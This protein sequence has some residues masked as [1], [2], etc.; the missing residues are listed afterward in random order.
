MKK[1]VL[2]LILLAITISLQ[3][4]QLLI[5]FS[6]EKA[7][8][9]RDMGSFM[10]QSKMEQTTNCINAFEKM[11]K[12]NKI[13]DTWFPKMA[14]NCNAMTERT[15]TPFTHFI[16]YLNAVMA[17]ANSKTSDTH[18][19]AW[20]DFIGDVI[21]GQKKGDNGGFLKAIDFSDSFFTDGSLLANASKSWKIIATDYKFES[22]GLRPYVSFPAGCTLLGCV[23]GDTLAIH[24]TSGDYYPLETKWEGKTGKVDWGRAGLDPGRVYCTFKNYAINTS[25]YNYAIDTVTF[26][27]AEYFKNTLTGKLIDKM[28]SSADTGTMSYP[29][30]QSYDQGL[31]VKDVAPNV[32]YTG[33]FSLFGN[34]VQGY[35]SGDEKAILTFYARDGKTKVLSAKANTVMIK[36][37]EELGADK[38]E[39]SIY[40]G[41][42]SIYHPQL[43]VVYKI[44]KREI[45]LLRGETGTGKAKFTDSYHNHEFQTDAIFWNLD[46]SVLNLKILSGAGQ[47]PGIY[48]SVNY[49]QKE[50]IRKNQG[51]A[52]Y[53]P[54]SI[55]KRM[56]DKQ[57][58]DRNLN[59][60]DVARTIDPNLKEGE[61]KSLLYQLVENGFINYNEEIGI[62]T[63][64]DKTLNYVLA[65]AKKIDYD[66]IH[67]RSAPQKGNDYIDLKSSN[68]DL[69]GVKSVPISDTAYVY[70]IPKNNAISLQKD[71]NMEFDG[72]IMGGRMDL[73]GEKY[74]FQ[75]APFT[76]DLTKVDT[77]RINVPD[78]NRVDEYGNPI[79]K[80]IRSRIENLK[81]L[82]EIDAPINKSGRTKLPQFPRLYSR[83]KSYIYY[84][85]STVAKGAYNRKTFYFEL[86]P[87]RLDSLNNFSVDIINWKGKLVSGGIFPDVKDSV[88]LQGDASLGFKSETPPGGYEI[89]GGKGKYWG[90]FELNYDG[91]AADGRIIHSTADFTSH[92]IRLYP[93]SMMGTTDSITIAKTFEGVKTPAV[94]G[95]FEKIFWKPKADSMHI[96]MMNPDHPFAMYD[97]GFTTFKGN[98]LLTAKDLRG[99]GLLDW[100]EAT[101]ESKDFAFHTM[102]LAADTAALNIKTTGDKVTFKTPNVNAKVDFKTRI[103]DFVSNQKN[104]PTEFSYNQ[105]T[106]AINQFKW[107]MDEKILDFKAPPG[108][109]GEYF[110]STRPDQKGLKFLGKRATYS[111]I[112]SVLR[113]EQVPEIKVADA[114]VIPDSG[115]VVIEAEAKMH[116]LLNAKIVS[117]T[118]NK[119]HTL[120]NA[121]VDI[122]SKEEL[123]GFGDYTYKTKD[124]KE[125]I[126]FADISC[127]KE[128]EGVRRKA[129]DIWQLN[130]KATI[131]KDKNFVV[132]PGV[133]FNGDVNLLSVNKYLN[134][135]GYANIDLKH[136]GVQTSDFSIDQDVDPNTLELKFDTKTKNANGNP[137]AAGIHLSPAEDAHEMYATFM[138]PKKDN[139]DITLFQSTGIVAQGKD[140]EYQFG[141]TAKIKSNNSRGN[142]LRYDDKKGIA[143]AEGEFKF[144]LNFGLIKTKTVGFGEVYLDSSKYKFNLTFGIDA[145]VDSKIQ[146]RIEFYMTGDNADQPD[147]SY[148]TEK[149]R[150]AIAMLTDEKA[151]RHLMEEFEKAPVFNKR[152]K[153]FDYNLVFNDVNFV[154]DSFDN[155]LRSV[156][157][158]GVA[159]IG[160]KVINKKLDGNIEFLYR[161]GADVM[162]IYLAL[163]TK[164]WL[165]FE[166]R[167]GTLG[168]LASY[169][170]INNG[171]GAIAPEKRK[172]QGPNKRFYVYTLGSSMNKTEFVSYMADKAKGINRERL[173]A[174][175]MI[176]APDSSSLP[177]E[178]DSTGGEFMQEKIT[179]E[180]REIQQRQQ[181]INNMEQM[182][183]SGQQIL[184][185]PPP[186]RDKPKKNEKKQEPPKTE[187]PAVDSL[188]QQA[189]GDQPVEQPKEKP[190]K[191]GKGKKGE[192]G[193]PEGEVAPVQ[194]TPKQEPP[195]QEQPKIELPPVE[196]PKTE[197]VKEEPKIETPPKQEP[198]KSET[199]PVEQPKAEPVKEQPKTETPPVQESP[200]QE[201]PVQEPPKSETPPVE[202]PKTEPVK[203]QPKTETPPVQE[204]PKQEPPVQEQPKSETPPVEPKAEP[205]KEQPKTET[206]AAQEAPKQEPPVQEQPKSETP[207]VQE[208]PK[209]E[210]PKE[211]PKTEAPKT[212]TPP[213]SEP[214]K[215]E[216]PK[217]EPKAETPKTEEPK[218][219]APAAP[220]T[221]TDS[222]PK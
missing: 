177:V 129:V 10:N 52:S 168:V 21:D 185:G 130:A 155:S 142:V 32:S 47:K 116:Q 220:V 81:G 121:T 156:G 36:K 183:M 141:D 148:D 4:Q 61:L 78:S 174:N 92:D 122:Y 137:V 56:V 80:P 16:P 204:T 91:M 136:A 50:L 216:P 98:L 149:Q 134:F 48:E 103:G 199:P 107:F 101:L 39:V 88:H 211:E 100:N 118:I 73:Y 71:R 64:K 14:A 68:I 173:N 124:I 67:L 161:G 18:F 112:T 49:F 8:F 131:A 158:I 84:D 212:E 30:F 75:Y 55:L 102:D 193:E 54:L 76:V 23:R 115:V 166:Y 110:T 108:G 3:A 28:V 60:T 222:V 160:K 147:I 2:P 66:I 69:K 37:G 120:E 33:G 31:T 210:P 176:L 53:E 63:V 9:T 62:I 85:D 106:T 140:G 188:Q 157:K 93:D 146:D 217:E 138:G 96:D 154:Y 128:R 144:G 125:V 186:G 74:K 87:F 189:P 152:P 132:Y 162:T 13:P 26:T 195:V 12:E 164:D 57:G 206:P 123:K 17:A 42:D 6:K 58:G 215:V 153:D 171:I 22:G 202:P 218:I 95:T 86:E 45:R 219:E 105:Y 79:L 70:F 7:Q 175:D 178:G 104:I 197:P 151:D 209:S 72:L 51:Y 196:Q 182:R 40:F 65:N 44:A 94:V 113:V 19:L 163:G 24:Q 27:Y 29:R 205:V 43:S 203:E 150:K 180:Q 5:T 214:Q 1:L 170:D 213:V 208:Q 187:E 90:K 114:S 59:A 25:N 167:P 139:K 126:N 207:P 111:L 159:M 83:E 179:P 194:E 184:S 97:D 38:A 135:K 82:L 11:V 181:E 127:K 34:K 77:M 133:G 200:K 192:T 165:Y 145:N 89:Y 169:D 143:K 109:P 99:N 221:P 201:P 20:S 15:M 119:W 46:S 190:K 41:S 191:K 35:G 117:D 172:I 198:P